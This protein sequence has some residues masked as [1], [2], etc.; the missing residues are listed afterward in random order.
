MNIVLK[1]FNLAFEKF[2]IK[3]LSISDIIKLSKLTLNAAEINVYLNRALKNELQPIIR[4]ATGFYALKYVDWKWKDLLD[5]LEGEN[6]LSG[7]NI[8]SAKGIYIGQPVIEG[9][10]SIKT[11]NKSIRTIKGKLT[12]YRDFNFNM[13]GVDLKT[14][15]ATPEKAIVDF[16][17]IR[18]NKNQNYDTMFNKSLW[19]FDLLTK[20]NFKKAL[21]YSS[22]EKIKNVINQIKKLL[23]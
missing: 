7:L 13:N 23:I 4:V 10:T 20:I 8:L 5:K 3:I 16:I 11:R 18:L 19:N 6:Y 14:K 9:V 22:N 21:K 15:F 17:R 12:L 2:G 1:Q